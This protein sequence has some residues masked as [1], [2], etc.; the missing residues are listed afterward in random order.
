MFIEDYRPVFVFGLFVCWAL[1]A[2]VT[3]DTKASKNNKRKT[4]D[5]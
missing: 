1:F 5:S 2:L 4:F 3:Q